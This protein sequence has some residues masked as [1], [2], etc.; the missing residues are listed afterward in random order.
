MKGGNE[1]HIGGLDIGT[2]G[3][4]I[5]IYNEKGEFLHKSYSEY[6]SI[7]N[8]EIQEIDAADV[9]RSVKK[10]LYEA[11][12]A[13]S[14]IDAIG[15]TSFGESFVLLDKDDNILM[16][17]MLYTDKRGNQEALCFDSKTVM[18]IAGVKP[19]GMYSL[20]KLMWIKENL[21]EVYDKTEKV[22]LFEDF[23][24][25][26]LTGKRQIDYSLAARTMGFD[27][28]NKC[29]SEKL[30]S[31]AGI[32]IEKM[33]EPVCGGNIV[34]KAVLNGFSDTYI[35]NG[36][37]DQLAA[38]I[39]AGVFEEGEAIDGT[40]TVECIVP[41]FNKI[42]ESKEFFDDGY[43]VVPHIFDGKY[44]C[45]ALSYTGGA[46]L[47]WYRDTFLN[48]KSYKELDSEVGE[49][50]TGILIMPHFAGAA[51]PYMDENSK[52]VIAGLTLGTTKADLYRA[53]MEGVTYEILLNLDRI[54]E[55]NITVK[56]LY[57]T[58]G[59]A[60]SQEWLQIKADILGRE[61]TALDTSETGTVGTVMLSSVALGACKNLYEARNIFVK[62]RKT[63]YPDMG[64]N[65]KYRVIYEK[66]KKIYSSAKGWQ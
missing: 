15:I 1:V 47:K 41:V 37:H 27:I 44:M 40:G 62:E 34:G 26:K 33:S 57:A 3:C 25:Y 32:D 54:S 50:P 9:W 11:K 38:V 23:I 36:C 65:K 31:V 8:S 56:K 16:P 61:I 19:H 24:V 58:G 64:K 55:E 4:K 29:W 49:E 66:Y 48:D 46:A 14:E 12:N 39:G 2:T 63:Y 7:R 13:V 5:S 17:S 43:P 18:R 45:Y 22:F 53:V 51:N 52:A 35:V 28:E 60:S 21:P 59:G 10:V 42:P 20:P 6:E 30:F